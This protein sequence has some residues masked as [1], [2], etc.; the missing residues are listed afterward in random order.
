[1]G[2]TRRKKYRK[3]R[4]IKKSRKLYKKIKKG[5]TPSMWKSSALPHLCKK[6]PSG[7]YKK[8]E[9]Y[10]KKWYDIDYSIDKATTTK[11]EPIYIFHEPSEKNAYETIDNGVHNFF[12]FYDTTSDTY[13]LVAS[14]FREPEYGT[15]HSMMI[16]RL[17]DSGEN[18]LP[19]N[20]II[21]GEIYKQGN[22]IVFNDFSSQYYNCNAE[23]N[24]KN[25]ID[26]VDYPPLVKQI[27]SDAFARIFG[28]K[29][30]DEIPAKASPKKSASAAAP[31]FIT[32]KPGKFPV[33]NY[34]EQ[35]FSYF[36]KSICTNNPPEVNFK[37]YENKEDCKNETNSVG[38][39]CDDLEAKSRKSSKIIPIPGLKIKN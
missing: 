17:E 8:C 26:P 29:V 5:G 6:Y 35:P 12:L 33:G 1:M 22:I 25:K 11:L 14:R 27:M 30:S 24:L 21:S 2:Q 9:Q 20:F 10:D 19:A 36:K 37:V 32:F 7:E 4:H 31:L 34:R 18:S 15:K 39:M 16:K 23:T 3:T 28:K 13:S 38:Q